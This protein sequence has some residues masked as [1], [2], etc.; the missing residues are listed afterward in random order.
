MASTSMSMPTPLLDDSS[1]SSL[2]DYALTSDELPRTKTSPNLSHQQRV[3]I[4][5]ALIIFTIAFCA[6]LGIYLIVER[7]DPPPSPSDFS[8]SS[9]SA[10]PALDSTSPPSPPS[11]PSLS[12]SGA[13]PTSAPPFSPPVAPNVTCAPSLSPAGCLR[14]YLSAYGLTAYIVPSND[15]HNSEYV[16]DADKRREFISNFTG[17]A[18]TALIIDL[19][20]QLNRLWTDSRYAIQVEQELDPSEWAWSSAGTGQLQSWVIAN[21]Q[22]ATI[23]IDPSLMSASVF[24]S[25]ASAYAAAGITFT[26]VL[27][28]LVDLVWGPAR[29]E[30]SQARLFSLWANVTG[31]TVQ[32]KVARVKGFMTPQRCTAMVVSALDDI[33]WVTNLQRERHRGDPRVHLLPRHHQHHHHCLCRPQQDGRRHGLRQG[34]RHH[35]QTLRHGLS[36]TSDY[37]T[38]PSPPPPECG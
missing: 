31:E 30:A 19:P 17:S 6:G 34:E 22:G 10:A 20:Q 28:N 37:S 23:G 11:P 18:G 21:L 12:S 1:A 15:E 33:A 26:G 5:A 38:N 32:Q 3:L 13:F 27:P 4:T 9:S 2:S 25:Q 16:A 8:S 29:P 24:T 7:A 14:R 35:V 36:Q